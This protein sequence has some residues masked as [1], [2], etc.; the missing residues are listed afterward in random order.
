MRLLLK[1]N[2]IFKNAEHSP[3]NNLKE[4]LSFLLLLE[5]QVFVSLGKHLGFV[6]Q[7]SVL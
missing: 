1:D 3:R 7:E 6:L 5:I 4:S 2:H